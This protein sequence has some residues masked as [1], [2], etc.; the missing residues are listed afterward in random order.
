MVN[1]SVSPLFR[2]SEAQNQIKAHPPFVDI[3]FCLPA[4]FFVILDH[5]E[6]RFSLPVEK[7]KRHKIAKD[8]KGT[9]K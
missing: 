2:F 5:A 9:Y 1:S 8:I 3:I 4:P 7:T 6:I